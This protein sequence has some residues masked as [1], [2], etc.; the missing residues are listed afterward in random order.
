MEGTPPQEKLDKEL[1]AAMDQVVVFTLDSALAGFVHKRKI[2]DLEDKVCLLE[3]EQTSALDRLKDMKERSKNHFDYL[4]A[5]QV[6]VEEEKGEFCR[7]LKQLAALTADK[8]FLSNTL[9]QEQS[10]RKSAEALVTKWFKSSEETLEELSTRWD[11]KT[12]SVR[13]PK[14]YE[15]RSE[16]IYKN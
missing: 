5:C 15:E 1:A 6:S 16:K 9:D 2:Q 14:E 10:A 13:V 4:Q 12:K 11:P 8:E 3:G 7:L